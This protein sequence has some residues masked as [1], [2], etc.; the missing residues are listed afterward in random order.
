[1][2]SAPIV[3]PRRTGE[4]EDD[5]SPAGNA[6]GPILRKPWP[7]GPQGRFLDG[8][9]GQLQRNQ[10]GFL[11]WCAREYGDFV[12]LRLGFRRAVLVNDPEYIEYV[13]VT[14][15]RNFVKTPALGVASALLGKGLLTSEGGLWRRQ[16]RLMQPAFH[17]Q[18]IAAYGDVMVRHTEAL[19]EQWRDGQRRDALQEMMGL[20]LRIVCEALFGASVEPGVVERVRDALAEIGEHLNARLY[21]LPRYLLPDAFPIPD[22]L[23]YKRNVR[24]LDE[25]VYGFIEQRRREG[26]AGRGDLLSLLLEARDDE[27][28]R[29]MS[30]K[31]LRDEVMTLFLAGH[32]TTSLA[33]AWTWYLLAQRPEVE[34]RLHE[35]HQRVLGGRTPGLADLPQLTFT[36]AVIAESMRLYPPAWST[37]RQAIADCEMDG[38]LLPKGTVVLISQWVTHRDPRYFENPEA[39]QPERWLDGLAKRLPKYAYYPFGGGPRMCIGNSFATME[40]ALLLTTIAQRYRLSMAAGDTVEPE[41]FFTLRPKNGVPVTL[42]AR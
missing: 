19:L 1:M 21:N 15:Q 37:G 32:E 17:R 2:A 40:A 33:L 12:P 39:F 42:Q 16:R 10:L 35:E 14:N 3:R 25:I 36:D 41:T 38:Y 20:T 24:L 5:A 26:T 29:G 30:D 28:G 13:L 22:N 4:G 8:N 27:D 23:R 31:Q 18:R 6:A 7:K 34:A 11:T 9:L